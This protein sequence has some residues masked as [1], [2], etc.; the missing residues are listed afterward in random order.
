[1]GRNRK[2]HD[3]ELAYLV[4]CGLNQR[5]I[6]EKLEVSRPT[7][8]D[9]IKHLRATHPELLE[10]KSIEEFR[11]GETEDLANM[12]RIILSSLRR[13]MTTTTL[14]AISLQQLGVLYGILFE[15]DRLLRGEATEHI[16]TATYAQ[17]DDKTRA[18]ITD[19]VSQLTKDM[20]NESRGDAE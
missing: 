17:L 8:S 10:E 3:L 16:A 7:V 19:A 4:G 18:V 20:L 9:A 2:I 11:K 14:N 6:A 5:E 13:K 15:K 1:M 12:R